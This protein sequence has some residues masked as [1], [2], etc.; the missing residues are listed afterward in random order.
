MDSRGLPGLVEELS[1]GRITRRAFL[2]KAL[3]LGVSLPIAGAVLAACGSGT[4]SSSS[5][6]SPGASAASVALMTMRTDLDMANVDPAF[7]VSHVDAAI[8]D[9]I[10]EGLVSFK[11]GTWDV[12]NTLAETFEPSSDGLRYHF[13]LKQGIPF[14]KG[15]GEVTADDVKFSYER[16]AGLTKPPLNAV[17]Q[18]DWGTLEAVQVSGKYEGTIVLKQPFAPLM[19]STLPVMSGKVLSQ[20]AVEKLGKQYATNPVGTGPYE[21]VSWVPKQQ[22]TLQRFASYAGANSSYAAKSQA[23]KLVLMPIASDAAA[24]NALISG[25]VDIGIIGT[26][27]LSQVQSGSGLSL[28]KVP[29]QSYYWLALN[30][31]DPLLSNI[32]LRKAI[33][34]AIDVPSIIAAAY[35]DA[36][37]RAYAILPP[38][39]KIG[40]WAQAPHYDQNLSQARTYLSQSGLKNVSLKLTVL[41]DTTDTTVAQVIQSNLASIGIKV[42]IDPQDAGTFYAIPGAGGGGPHRQLVYSEYS[43]EPDPSWSFEWW[44]AAQKNLWNWDDWYN[45]EFDNLLNRA[46]VELN[47][48]TRNQLYV[49]AQ[50]LWDEEASMVWIAF[51][52]RYFAGKKQIKPSFRPDGQEVIWNYREV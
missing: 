37:E 7:W 12:V 32:N 36:Y 43:T 8:G 27:S 48:A 45:A 16:I 46:L 41:S 18:A 33:R 50:Q 23:E 20:K 52:T 6:A 2:M 21:F 1:S 26:E 28:Y 5:S 13:T 11:P 25:S 42:T 35:N 51:I 47:P 31:T 24:V 9:A 39:M 38:S 17:Y 19:L 29:T 49:Q 30:V 15:Y 14:Q 34:S 44:T 10:Y 40:Y 22:V 4:T 3:A